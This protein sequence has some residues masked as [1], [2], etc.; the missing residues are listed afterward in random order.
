[1][2]VKDFPLPS[3]TTTS[4]ERLATNVTDDESG[5]PSPSTSARLVLAVANAGALDG[6]ADA[7]AVAEP[8]DAVAAAVAE[9][10][11]AAGL[12]GLEDGAPSAPCA[13]TG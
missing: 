11:T 9:V 12:D 4:A 1:M 5:R 10:V 6:W 2:L 13:V 8:A 7:D 3:R